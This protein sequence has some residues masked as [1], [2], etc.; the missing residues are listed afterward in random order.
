MDSSSDTSPSAPIITSSNSQTVLT[1]PPRNVTT[2]PTSPSSNIFDTSS[3][4]SSSTS[5]TNQ[6]P[7]SEIPITPP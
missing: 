4:I 6:P 7:I 3:T 1:N 5:N 2:Q